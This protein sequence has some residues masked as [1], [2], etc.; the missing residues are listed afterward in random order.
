LRIANE[1]KE[2]AKEERAKAAREKRELKEENKRRRKETP[3]RRRDWLAA[4]GIEVTIDDII[5]PSDGDVPLAIQ[6]SVMDIDND[7]D[8]ESYREMLD[9]ESRSVQPQEDVGESSTGPSHDVS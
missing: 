1:E 8:L 5:R 3:K 4:R 9:Q 2:R 6:Q 7:E